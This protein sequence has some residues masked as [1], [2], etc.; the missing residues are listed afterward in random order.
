M[1]VL[2][3]AACIGCLAGCEDSQQAVQAEKAR[4]A[5]V[6][7]KLVAAKKQFSAFVEEAA[8]GVQLLH[9]HP[10]RDALDQ[11]YQKLQ[12]LLDRAS[13]ISPGQETAED[14]ADYG[15]RMM[16][17]FDACLSVAN[18]QSKQ[19]DRSPEDA[20]RFIDKTCEGNA[21]PIE[22]FIQMMKAKLETK[23]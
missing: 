12:K 3:I 1:R 4:Q 19:K 22:Q 13:S 5:A 7:A 15:H 23:P 2:L 18:Y 8:K 6:A 16:N 14:L 10:D 21:G 11:E 20:R 17:F 9:S